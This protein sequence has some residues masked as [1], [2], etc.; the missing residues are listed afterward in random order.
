MLWLGLTLALA[1]DPSGSLALSL[2]P[3]ATVEVSPRLVGEAIEVTVHN[4]HVPLREQLRGRAASGIL[5][6]SSVSVGG[7]TWFLTVYTTDRGNTV[8]VEDTPDGVLLRPVP[9]PEAETPAPLEP[10]TVADLAADRVHP[11]LGVPPTRTLL[12][13]LGGAAATSVASGHRLPLVAWRGPSLT[14]DQQSQLSGTTLGWPA[15]TRYNHALVSSEDAAL[16]QA[17]RYRL[18]VAYDAMALPRES[19]HYLSEMQ[20]NGDRGLAVALLRA[21]SSMR[22]GDWDGMRQHCSTATEAD[23]QHIATLQ[24]LAVLAVQTGTPSAGAAG[25]LLLERSDDPSAQLLASRA[26]L[27]DHHYAEALDVLRALIDVA[28]RPSPELLAVWGDAE[29]AAGDLDQARAA[30]EAVPWDSEPGA[31]G[32]VRLHQID[33]L[34][35]GPTTWLA[36]LP[37]LHRLVT[38]PD[39]VSSEA[40]QLLAQIGE[41]FGDPETEALALASLLSRHRAVARQSDVLSRLLV[42]CGG[43]LQSLHGQGRFVE[44]VALYRRCWDP[45]L[46][47]VVRETGPVQQVADAYREL[48]LFEAAL[49]VQLEVARMRSRDERPDNAATTRLAALYNDVDRPLEALQTVEYVR[50]QRPD[51]S[52]RRALMTEAARAHMALEQ[53]DAALLELSRARAAD[54]EARGMWADLMVDKLGCQAVASEIGYRE[55]AGQP[56]LV[57]ATRCRLELGDAIGAQAVRMDS[58]HPAHTA[59]SASVAVA[60]GVPLPEQ[61]EPPEWYEAL[62]REEAAFAELRDRLNRE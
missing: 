37:E 11:P 41:R 59:Q 30:W 33:M 58:A 39:R 47:D 51:A 42:S 48:S 21:R 44:Q 54:W 7:G 35:A 29:L 55:E 53:T 12:P 57:H 9:A 10:V 13:L 26:L 23:L 8:A 38:G 15:I 24:C 3:G 34:E 1:Q 52:L 16:K 56:P 5:D 20:V 22:L 14:S 46:N 18:A 6:I 60:Q 40:L 43:R 36:K 4:N 49:D 45:M 32:R 25:R 2:S 27:R 19:D 62:A 50:S 31:L 28:E 61:T 17:A